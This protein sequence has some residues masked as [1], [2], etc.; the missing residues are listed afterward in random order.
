M[1]DFNGNLVLIRGVS[2][3]GKSLIAS[4][5][6][7]A[8]SIATDNLFYDDD[9]KYNFDPSKLG[10][11]HN[12]TIMSVKAQMINSE[13]SEDYELSHNLI[14]VH[15]TFTEE[16]QMQP[17]IDL[18]EKYNWCVSTIIVE[19]RHGSE[20]IHNVPAH[21]IDKQKKELSDNIIL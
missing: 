19:N 21:S 18:A 13:T 7:G 10:E 8:F 6:S 17:Y 9:G 11:Y 14:V 20:S 1:T 16:W 5:F 12:Y 2:G 3:A 4:L 15:N